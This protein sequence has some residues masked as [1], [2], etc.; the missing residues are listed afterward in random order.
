MSNLFSF[1]AVIRSIK[2]DSPAKTSSVQDASKLLDSSFS[3]EK[4]ADLEI[5]SPA[6]KKPKK[7][8]GT[9]SPAK[10]ENESPATKK[11]KNCDGTPSQKRKR[12]DMDEGT[13][14]NLHL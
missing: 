8:Y 5:E 4:K 2:F 3:P 10:V 1:V 7:C 13:Y 6:T 12:S 14:L 11:P 9:P